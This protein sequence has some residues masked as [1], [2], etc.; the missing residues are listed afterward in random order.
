VEVHAVGERDEALPI[1]DGGGGGGGG[2]GQ[3][4]ARGEGGVDVDVVGH[5]G[6]GEVGRHGIENANEAALAQVGQRMEDDVAER[7]CKRPASGA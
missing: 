6:A 7:V 2:Q 3:L 5:T 4:N 1:G